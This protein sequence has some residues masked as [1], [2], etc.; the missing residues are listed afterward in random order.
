VE[1]QGVFAFVRVRNQDREPVTIIAGQILGCRDVVSGCGRFVDRPVTIPPGGIVTLATVMSGNSQNGAAFSYRCE[2]QTRSARFTKSAVSGRQPDD[3]RTVMSPQEVRAAEAAAIGRISAPAPPPAQG[4]RNAPPRA[5]APLP[6]VAPKLVQ[7]G[8]TRLGIG[9]R[10]MA[11]VRVGIGAG[12]MAV[13]DD[14]FDQQSR[15]RRRGA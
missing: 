3:P 15:A 10:G 4:T 7:R 11:V 6:F 8:S 1:N 5:P 9:Q 13:R 2:V 14:H 12:G